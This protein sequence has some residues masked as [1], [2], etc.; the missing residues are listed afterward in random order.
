M[1]HY[2]FALSE[3]DRT[4]IIQVVSLLISSVA[5]YYTLKLN[6]T[7][8]TTKTKLDQVSDHI[9]D[10]SE[11]SVKRDEE[12]KEMLGQNQATT[13][14][15]HSIVNGGKGI[16]LTELAVSNRRL[17]TAAPTPANILAAEMSEKVAREHIESLS[18][19][20]Q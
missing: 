15:V 12:V 18:K 2:M 6:I 11:K 5:A 3:P 14:S 13:D 9:S 19:K 1:I 17:A 4:A 20:P 16:L 7:S 10:A 8:K